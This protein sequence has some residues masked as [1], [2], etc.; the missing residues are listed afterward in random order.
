MNHYNVHF[1]IQ[2]GIA[3]FSGIIGITIVGLVYVSFIQAFIG[4]YQTVTALFI[5]AFYKQ[6]PEEIKK[7]LNIYALVWL[8]NA[9]LTLLLFS[10]RNGNWTESDVLS[11]IVL[12]LFFLIPWSS[13]IYFITILKKLADWKEE[14]E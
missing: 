11:T 6:Y 10:G 14:E 12:V 13:A 5:F 8:I 4:I 2:R 3:V 1:Q 9:I 7:H